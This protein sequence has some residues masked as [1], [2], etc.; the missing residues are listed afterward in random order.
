M[1]L[2][3]HSRTLLRPLRIS[4]SSAPT[5]SVKTVSMWSSPASNSMMSELGLVYRFARTETMKVLSVCSTTTIIISL[6]HPPFTP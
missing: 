3:Q 2:G 1:P 6:A 4:D 5:N